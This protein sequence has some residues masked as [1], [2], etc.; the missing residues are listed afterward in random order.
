[1][2]AVGDFY[3]RGD[4]HT[5]ACRTCLAS[6]AAARQRALRRTGDTRFRQMRSEQRRRALERRRTARLRNGRTVADDCPHRVYREGPTPVCL[7]CGRFLA[8]S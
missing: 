6:S 3:V 2:K 4:G 8:R 7:A 1:M 5:S